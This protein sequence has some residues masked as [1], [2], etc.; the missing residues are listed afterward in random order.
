[1]KHVIIRPKG[2]SL[3]PKC[4][5]FCARD[6]TLLCWWKMFMN[7]D[8]LLFEENFRSDSTFDFAWKATP[9]N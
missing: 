6:D 7:E 4:I 8:A 9:S 1:M 2:K 3:S 5:Y